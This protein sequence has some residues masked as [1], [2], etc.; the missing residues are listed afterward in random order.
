MPF[1]KNHDIS[2]ASSS[3]IVAGRNAV[4]EVIRSG[5]QIE[6]IMVANGVGG[7]V[8]PLISKAKSN[9]IM[10]KEMPRKKLDSKL[11]GLNHQ[12]IAAVVS[13]AEYVELDDILKNASKVSDPIILVLNEIE[14]PHNLGAI[15]RT[16]EAASVSGIVIPKRRSAG[17]NS[18]VAKVAAG[19]VEYVPVARV[20]NLASAI[21]TLKEN[22]FWVYG[23]DMDGEDVY[24]TDITGKTVL[25]IGSE[26]HG[27]NKLIRE[28][29]DAIVSL[30]M[31]G[32]INSLNASVAAGVLI[33][34]AVR[35][36]KQKN[37]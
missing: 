37:N 31:L 11:L 23:A 25:V 8:L 1:E 16:A 24:S 18:T 34:E 9:G 21:D 7:S 19:A 22:G 10:I 6:Y 3:D 13:S 29:C 20:A 30:P 28:K 36:R 5:R 26:G 27:M 2:V 14:D 35:Q 17:L 4:A 12:G 15:I 32:N 33:Y